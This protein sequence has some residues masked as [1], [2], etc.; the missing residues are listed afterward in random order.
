[1]PSSAVTRN[2]CKSWEGMTNSG[3]I[4]TRPA[5]YFADAL[6]ELMRQLKRNCTDILGHIFTEEITRGENGQF[7]TP[8]TVCQFMAQIMVPEPTEE[9]F[10]YNDP[11][12]GSGRMLLAMQ[13]LA[14]NANL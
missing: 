2:I 9:V 10:T 8:E 12:C 7:F 11:C 4:G 14:P 1:M 13:K 5:D 6:G 3:V